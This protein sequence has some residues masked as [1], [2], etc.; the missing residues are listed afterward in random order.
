MKDY[1]KLLNEDQKFV[2]FIMI[3]KSANNRTIKS[4][5]DK[6]NA[7]YANAGLD[8]GKQSSFDV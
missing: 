6:I 7:S 2:Y 4:I 1:V 5:A 8:T 3:V